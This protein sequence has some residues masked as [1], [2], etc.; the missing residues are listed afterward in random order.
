LEHL[1]K[2]DVILGLD[3]LDEQEVTIQFGP[4]GQRKIK[5]KTHTV[6][7]EPR[8]ERQRE[9]E[10][11][12]QSSSRQMQL[13]LATDCARGMAEMWSMAQDGVEEE[14]AVTRA[15]QRVAPAQELV[16]AAEALWQP[17]STETTEEEA[18]RGDITSS[19]QLQPP[20]PPYGAFVEKS[21]AEEDI[22]FEEQLKAMTEGAGALDS[23]QR[24]PANEEMTVAL[25]RQYRSVFAKK[26]NMHRLLKCEPVAI[27]TRHEAPIGFP[28]RPRRFSFQQQQFISGTITKLLSEG[29]IEPSTSAYNAPIVLVPKGESWRMCN[30]YRRLNENTVAI[31]ISMPTTDDVIERLGRSK[32][33][34]KMDCTTA[35]YQLRLKLEDR[36]KT[37]F[38]CSLG[39]FQYTVCPF[40][41]KNLPS[42]FNLAVSTLFRDL[43][44]IFENFFDDFLCFSDTTEEYREYLEVVERV[45]RRCSSINMLLSPDKSFFGRRTLGNCLGFRVVR[46]HITIADKG[47]AAVQRLAPPRNPKEVAHVLG[48]VGFWRHL[49]WGF[50]QRA[51]PLSELLKAGTPWVWGAR[52]QTAFEE[53]KDALQ[54]EPLMKIPIR[55][56][57]AGYT[58]FTVFTDASK[59]TIAAIL[60][61]SLPGTPEAQ[62][63]AVEELRPC[64]FFS[65][66]MTVAER[67]YSTTEREGL[68][69]VAALRKFHPWLMG[70]RFTVLTDHRA[71]QYLMQVPEPTDRL[72]RWMMLIQGYDM[73]IKHRPGNRMGHVDALTRLTLLEEEIDAKAAPTTVQPTSPKGA[74]CAYTVLVDAVPMESD[75]QLAEILRPKQTRERDGSSVVDWAKSGS[76]SNV[77]PLGGKLFVVTRRGAK[78]SK[79]EAGTTQDAQASKGGKSDLRS[80]DS[81]SK[82]TDESGKQREKKASN[83]HGAPPSKGTTPAA[84]TLAGSDRGRIELPRAVWHEDVW[85]STAVLQSVRLGKVVDGVPQRFH[86]RIREDMAN[87][88]VEFE[89]GQPV[90][91]RVRRADAQ[92]E[93][94]WF[95]CPPP[96]Q[97]LDLVV[98]A[99]VFGHRGASKTRALLE[100]RGLSW[101]GMTQD[102]QAVLARCR[103]CLQDNQKTI[104]FHPAM[105]IEVPKE[106][107]GRVHMD[108]LELDES[109][110]YGVQQMTYRYILLFVDA[111][112]KFPIAVI[113][114]DK[115][116]GG[117]AE[118]LWRVISTFGAPA[119]LVS[120]QGREF[121]NDVVGELC[122]LHG[123]ERRITSGYRPMA[124]GQVERFNRSL[125]LCLR[126]CTA[127]NPRQWPAW[128]DYVLLTIRTAHHSATGMTPFS[129]MFGRPYY[130]LLP[131]QI[132]LQWER[133][134]QDTAVKIHELA[135]RL[136]HAEEMRDRATQTMRR[137]QGQQQKTQDRRHHVA[138]DR[139]RPGTRVFV[140][141]E[142]GDSKLAHRFTG[143]F[144]VAR[145]AA[146]GN[147]HLLDEEKRELENT[148]PRDKL[149]EVVQ[150]E[151]E[152]S[153][154]QTQLYAAVDWER[155]QL[156]VSSVQAGPLQRT[157][158]SVPENE[159][160][161]A[162]ECI[163]QHDADAGKVLVKWEGYAEPTWIS[164]DDIADECRERL[165]REWKQA[166]KRMEGVGVAS[167]WRRRGRQQKGG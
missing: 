64:R 142:R 126:K 102:V 47:L 25:L 79:E 109:E 97:R 118:G 43:K 28:D 77:W 131:W 110:P 40:G 116:M 134:D 12:D 3:F 136:K 48:L 121:V 21:E 149:F 151:V 95:K 15:L 98:Q 160:W 82:P 72:A 80:E 36:V 139:L 100:E 127:E 122:R 132:L 42:Q 145:D 45:L 159:E 89:E 6:I 65:R 71:L 143:P 14:E 26:V 111:L 166:E 165:F 93:E 83:G 34:S 73:H 117:V 115:E 150:R 153:L 128:V 155:V 140:R 13:L 10:V 133:A 78:E 113:L 33:I 61:Q 68:A 138:V 90:H 20:Q 24:C 87:V 156:D 23:G 104:F 158:G 91:I 70:A 161:Y 96:S 37:A 167:R 9:A 19:S 5:F 120:D 106:V 147:Y 16:E 88:E 154:R 60:C 108:L 58:R 164:E 157:K 66:K 119:I 84:P 52:E 94:R 8:K 46:H 86:E 135:E 53:L 114:P 62:W 163:L 17:P 74:L 49:I 144:V 31:V 63:E 39:V 146:G 50:A 105:A 55:N 162:V 107:F 125:L 123:V 35:Y 1:K 27:H 141:V 2:Y 7:L 137:R 130:P 18:D 59:T 85:M 67:N 129:V 124:N 112:S 11:S 29:I 38:R 22:E 4:K 56:G 57:E 69:V 99:H 41:L 148:F 44:D 32:Y 30:D 51:L 103:V 75:Q 101:V 81:A 92:G 76:E 152:Q 54:K